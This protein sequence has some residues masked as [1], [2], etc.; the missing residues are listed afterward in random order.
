ML[1]LPPI[2]MLSIYTNYERIPRDCK[3]PWESCEFG[4]EQSESSEGPRAHLE[5]I[6]GQ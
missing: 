5:F 3:D 6:N 2:A 4:F 1:K